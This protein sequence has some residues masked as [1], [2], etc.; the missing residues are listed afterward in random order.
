MPVDEAGRIQTRSA[1]LLKISSIG[2]LLF[3]VP[4]L[5]K[6]SVLSL[7]NFSKPF[8]FFANKIRFEYPFW[9]LTSKSTPHMGLIPFFT[10]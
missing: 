8:L 1:A 6:D 9:S 10:A 3:S 4:D 2:T 7:N 5:I